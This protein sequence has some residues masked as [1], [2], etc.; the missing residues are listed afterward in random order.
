M[1]VGRSATLLPT[2]AR[3]WAVPTGFRPLCLRFWLACAKAE[4]VP[5]GAEECGWI[6]NQP[7]AAYRLRVVVLLQHT[8]NIS[9]WNPNANL[10]YRDEPHRAVGCQDEYRRLGNASFLAWVVNGPFLDDATPDVGEDGERQPQLPPHRLRLLWGIHRYSHQVGTGSTN[11]FGVFAIFRQLA[12]TKWSPMAAI[13]Q[14]NQR[15]S[16]DQIR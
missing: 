12:K 9:G 10:I 6:G 2:N 5:G 11:S 14:Q 1:G 16:G 8:H 15:T 13:E 4:R 7:L 3:S